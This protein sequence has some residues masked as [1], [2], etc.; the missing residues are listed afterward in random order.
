MTN[1]KCVT[2]FMA[3]E[4]RVNVAITR[5]KGVMWMI[6]GTMSLRNRFSKVAPNL[7]TQYKRE[8][9]AAGQTHHFKPLKKRAYV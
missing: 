9:D 2:G 4:N 1:N 5:A 7:L 6:G 3:D 8:L